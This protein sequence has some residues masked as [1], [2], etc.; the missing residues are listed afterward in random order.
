MSPA[1]GVNAPPLS[2][3]HPLVEG[4]A[5]PDRTDEIDTALDLR[6]AIAQL[7]EDDRVIL[8]GYFGLGGLPP[9]DKQV[10]AA[11]LGIA[12]HKFFARKIRAQERLAEI[13]GGAR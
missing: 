11:T 6:S 4:L 12:P 1:A 8:R 5:G 13:L 7:G 10:L 2:L 9:I 3:A